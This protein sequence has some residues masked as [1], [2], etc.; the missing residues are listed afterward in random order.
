[1][2]L[3]LAERHDALRLDADLL[4]HVIM[5]LQLAHLLLREV[6]FVIR[7][8]LERQRVEGVLRMLLVEDVVLAILP[9]REVLL[10]A[11]E[12]DYGLAVVVEVFACSLLRAG[13]VTGVGDG[14]GGLHF[15]A[16]GVDDSGFLLQ[17]ERFS[18][19]YD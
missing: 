8:A 15:H 2:R 6:L 16:V 12:P 17:V 7:L 4:Q 10:I 14:A 18:L 3:I 13:V 9:V 11:G 19:P 1:M 5:L